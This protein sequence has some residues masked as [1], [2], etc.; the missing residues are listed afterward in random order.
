MNFIESFSQNINAETF[1]TSAFSTFLI[2]VHDDAQ[3]ETE[4]AV[5]IEYY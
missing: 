1:T 5:M 3:T 2:I 4:K